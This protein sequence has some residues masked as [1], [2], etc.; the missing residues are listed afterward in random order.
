MET[1]LRRGED[2]V[3]LPARGRCADA[4]PAPNWPRRNARL[5]ALTAA[6]ERANDR[7]DGDRA[8]RAGAAPRSRLAIAEL[9]SLAHR[10]KGDLRPRSK[11]AA[12]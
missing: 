4:R 8:L 9:D 1:F 2:I 3:C 6:A 12:A 5:K 7:H 11:P 10:Q